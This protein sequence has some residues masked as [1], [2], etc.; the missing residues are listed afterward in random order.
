M[1]L[2][3]RQLLGW[4]G[5]AVWAWAGGARAQ[6]VQTA[7][8][9]RDDWVF[10]ANEVQPLIEAQGVDAPIGLIA[11]LNA[12]LAQ[13]QIALLVCLVPVKVRVH[14]DQLPDDVALSAAQL[15]R[16]ARYLDALRQAG[17]WAVD[18]DSAFQASAD[19][20]SNTPLYYRQDSHWSITGADLAAQTVAAFIQ[21]QPALR[22]AW[23][24]SPARAYTR[25]LSRPRHM[26][27]QDLLSLLPAQARKAHWQTDSYPVVGVQAPDDTAASLVGAA[28]SPELTLVGSSYSINWTGFANMLRLHLQR[29]LLNHS[30]S[31]STG[32]WVNL[33]TYLHDQAF[34]TQPPGLIILEIPERDLFA[35][36]DFA[37]REA[38]YRRSDAG[39]LDSVRAAIASAAHRR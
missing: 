34:Q 30:A 9:G 27:A 37:Y 24:A 23:Q 11:A 17:V 4:F 29:D 7:F 20:H 28:T 5:G 8:V 12:A 14:A 2:S 1:G 3:R 15:N 16:Y 22:A 31:A 10:Y 25:V 13:R 33:E 21:A 19:R 18:L 6:A 26:R 35:G 38:A 39:W 32:M 36:P